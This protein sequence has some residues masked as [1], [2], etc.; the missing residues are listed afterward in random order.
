MGG[1]RS[2]LALCLAG[3]AASAGAQ[4]EGEG[5]TP[6]SRGAAR[7]RTGRASRRACPSTS[8]PRPTPATATRTASAVPFPFK[9]DQL[10]PGQTSGFEETVNPGSHFEVSTLTLSST[11]PGARGSLAH[12]KVDFIDLYDRNPTSTDKK[13]DVD[14]A[15]IRFGREADP[16]TLPERGGVYLKVGKFPKFERQDDRHLESYGLVST[17]FNRFEDAGAELGLD[18]GRHL[19]VKASATQGNPVF[20]RDPNALAGRQRHARAAGHGTPNPALKQRHRRSSTTPRSRTWT[21]TATSSSGGG[22]GLRF[23]DAAGQQRRRRPRLGLPAQARATRVELEGTFYGGDLDLLDGPGSRRRRLAADHGRRQAGGGGQ[24]LAL[25]GRPLALRPVRRPGPRRPRRAPASRPRL[26]WRFDLPLVWALGDRQLF[27]S[28]AP[29][30]RYSKLDNDFREPPRDRRRRASPGTGRRSTP[31]C[32]WGS[33]P[34]IDLTLEYADNDFILGSGAERENN[35]FLATLRW[36]SEAA[37]RR[38]AWS[39]L[40]LLALPARRLRVGRGAARAGRARWRAGGKGPA[41]GSDV[42]QAVVYF[43]PAAA[44]ARR[45][46]RPPRPSRWSPATSSSCRGSSPCRAAAGCASPTG[47]HPPQRL[48]GLARATASTSASTARGRAR[49]RRFEQP[50]L[51]R[52]FCNVHHSMVA[53]V[54]VLDTPFSPRPTPT[55][56]SCSPGLPRG[57][58]QAHRLARAGRALDG[59]PRCRCR[60]AAAARGRALEVVRPRIPPHLN[61]PASPTS[62]PAVTATTS[63]SGAAGLSLATRIFLVTSLLI[64]L[65]VGAA[66][67]VTVVLHQA[68]RPRRG[69][70]SRSRA[71]PRCR[72]RCRSSATS[73]CS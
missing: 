20:L 46:G 23:A 55:G 69:R 4:G 8:R 50:G 45:R 26:A 6:G 34:G 40:L 61:K 25:P 42:R 17:A 35:E 49:S 73:S 52:V 7:R 54:L 30:V 37:M 16:G 56:S 24:P 62:R 13:V 11:P 15:W 19:Y 58:G 59:G 57:A 43:E 9:P 2:L 47:P 21:S 29:A 64:A 41:R 66:V 51:V 22:L 3:P 60:P 33:S 12:A 27:P 14:E 5:G 70:A 38:L 44:A 10:P 53:Y 68:H 39:A 71:A 63:A 31:A 65:A 32:A 48:L 1:P 28:I 36:R 18:L 72:R 67:A